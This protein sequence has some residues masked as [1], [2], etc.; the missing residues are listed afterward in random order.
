MPRGTGQQNRCLS[1]SH[2]GEPPAGDDVTVDIDWSSLNYKD[3][4]AHAGKGKIIEISRWCRDRP[5]GR[6][7]TSEDTRFSRAGQQVLLGWGVGENYWGGLAAGARKGDLADYDA[8]ELDGRKAMIIGT[9]VSTA[10]CSVRRWHAGRGAGIRLT[11]RRNCRH[12]R[13]RRRGQRPSRCCTKL[14]YQVAA[15]SGRESTHDYHQWSKPHSNR[16]EFAETAAGKTV[17]A[18]AVKTTIGDKVLAKVLAQM[19]YGGCVAACGLAGG[20]PCRRQ[21]VTIYSA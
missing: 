4:L 18:G 12:R 7:H 16:D 17:W 11:L 9:A 8:E 19:N 2:R 20:L 3:A 6:V 5:A 14:G 21:Y 13:Q 1:A 15:V 10:P